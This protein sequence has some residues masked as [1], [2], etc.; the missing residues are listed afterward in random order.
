MVQSV[1]LGIWLGVGFIS[2]ARAQS[3]PDGTMPRFRAASCQ[4]KLR[5]QELPSTLFISLKNNILVWFV[6]QSAR[7]FNSPSTAVWIASVSTPNALLTSSDDSVYSKCEL[8]LDT[9]STLPTVFRAY[10]RR[11]SSR[12]KTALLP[13]EQFVDAPRNNIAVICLHI[14][15]SAP[16]IATRGR[17]LQVIPGIE[18]SGIATP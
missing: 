4:H 13:R 15:T 11:T 1:R 18:W 9:P 17:Y 8:L 12:W 6:N 10:F 3:F 5:Y 16:Q 14:H 2:S 7:L